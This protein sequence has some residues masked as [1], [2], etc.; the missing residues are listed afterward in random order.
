[1]SV[2]VVLHVWAGS[3]RRWAA[4]SG[5]ERARR[6]RALASSHSTSISSSDASLGLDA[7]LAE[8]ALDVM[9]AVAE[10]VGGDA[11]LALGID[12]EVARQIDDREQQVADLARELRSR[13]RRRSLGLDLVQLL[14]HLGERARAVGPVEAHR[15]RL[16]L[17]AIGRDQRRQ[18]L[19][20]L[21][22]QRRAGRPSRSFLISCHWR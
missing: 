10:A 4:L 17:D 22:E 11:Q 15:G 20:L 7:A 8:A 3:A 6:G 21:A 16:L 12:P 18:A 5:A 13:C 9:E 2:I 19:G 1:M 14:A